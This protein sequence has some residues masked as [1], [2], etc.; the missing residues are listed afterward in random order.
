MVWSWP[1]AESGPGS[2]LR[3]TFRTE[4]GLLVGEATCTTAVACTVTI[5]GRTTRTKRGAH[6]DIDTIVSA[7][8]EVTG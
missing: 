3:Y 2:L 7:A 1:T 5:A 6:V 4:E 8:P